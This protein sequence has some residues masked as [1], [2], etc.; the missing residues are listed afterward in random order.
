MLRKDVRDLSKFLRSVEI[1]CFSNGFKA[2][3]CTMYIILTYTYGGAAKNNMYIYSLQCV[4][5]SLVS[6]AKISSTSHVQLLQWLHGKQQQQ[7][8]LMS[9]QCFGSEVGVKK[10]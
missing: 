1:S 4:E 5:R 6:R 2:N 7:Q 10:K 8:L 9:L 3:T